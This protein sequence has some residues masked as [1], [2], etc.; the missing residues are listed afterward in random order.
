[1]GAQANYGAEFFLNRVFLVSRKCHFCNQL[2]HEIYVGHENKYEF[3]DEG[4]LVPGSDDPTRELVAT[5]P[6]AKASFKSKAVPKSIRELFHE[7]ERCRSIGAMTGVSACLR[8]AV[9]TLCDDQKASGDT[10]REKITNLPVTGEVYKELLR[11]VKFIGDNMTKPDGDNYTSV[12]ID[13]AL[14]VL[15]V[16]IDKVYEQDE[17]IDSAQKALAAARQKGGQ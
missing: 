2:F 3:N 15:P 13:I 6:A 1:M 8:K 14:G 16:V 4:E 11:Q 9:Y 5:Y 12:Q 7:A 10:Y 17:Q